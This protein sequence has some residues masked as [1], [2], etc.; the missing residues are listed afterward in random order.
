VRCDGAG[1]DNSGHLPLERKPAAPYLVVSPSPIGFN[2]EA[3]SCLK[4]DVRG[5][6]RM[7]SGPLF[8]LAV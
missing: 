3:T 4:I 6:G 1:W 7:Y 2:P 8:P 5:S